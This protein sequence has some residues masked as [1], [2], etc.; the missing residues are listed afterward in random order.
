MKYS[1]HEE[2]ESL[3]ESR[4]LLELWYLWQDKQSRQ[5]PAYRR[6]CLVWC[7]ADRIIKAAEVNIK[8]TDEI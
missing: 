3:K 7:I 6:F 5:L 2:L 1:Y 8:K 4:F